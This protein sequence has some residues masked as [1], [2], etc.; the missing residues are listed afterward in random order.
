MV[1]R[2]IVF[3]L[4][5]QNIT[6]LSVNAANTLPHKALRNAGNILEASM[7]RQKTG[8]DVTC[9]RCG[10]SPRGI[11]QAL[12]SALGGKADMDRP[13]KAAI[14]GRQDHSISEPLC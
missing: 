5:L 3:S 11:G 8:T 9:R 12:M 14:L 2:F 13:F 1:N 7:R 6:Q 4:A 10:I